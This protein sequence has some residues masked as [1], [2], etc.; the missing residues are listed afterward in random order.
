MLNKKEMEMRRIEPL[1]PLSGTH[2]YIFG[3]DFNV[4]SC[5]AIC[6]SLRFFYR[7]DSRRTEL[8]A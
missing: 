4:M 3:G 1:W 2:T 7:T 6:N 8:I 5:L